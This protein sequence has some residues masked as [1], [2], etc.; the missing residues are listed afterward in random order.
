[1]VSL[2]HVI[3][4]PD[5]HHAVTNRE[6][7]VPEALRIAPDILT[8]QTLNST[9]IP[10]AVRTFSCSTFTA[11]DIWRTVPYADVGSKR[12][13]GSNGG[14]DAQCIL[15]PSGRRHGAA[16][17]VYRPAL[18]SATRTWFRAGGREKFRARSMQWHRPRRRP[19]GRRCRNRAPECTCVWMSARL[20]SAASRRNRNSGIADQLGDAP[21]SWAGSRAGEPCGCEEGET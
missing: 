18:P 12:S 19:A 8:R 3:V 2:R 16:Y 21:G 10:S 15:L 11:R 5:E 20:R 7:G 4:V 13:V 1:M 14:R 9:T 6:E 17:T